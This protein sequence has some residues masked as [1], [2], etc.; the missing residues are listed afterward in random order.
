MMW[1]LG[2]TNGARW[3]SF[4]KMIVMWGL[5]AVITW[6]YLTRTVDDDAVN[7]SVNRV[8]TKK[9]IQFML[10]IM[11]LMPLILGAGTNFSQLIYAF[12]IDKDLSSDKVMLEGVWPVIAVITA[13]L[14][15][16]WAYAWQ[17]V[18]KSLQRSKLKLRLRI[19]H[20]LNFNR[21][22]NLGETCLIVGSMALISLG[23]MLLQVISSKTIKW[24][25]WVE[26]ILFFVALIWMILRAVRL[27]REFR[28][29]WIKATIGPKERV[30]N[31][32][33]VPTNAE[34]FAVMDA[35][36]WI[37]VIPVIANLGLLGWLFWWSSAGHQSQLSH[38]RN[39]EELALIAKQQAKKPKD[40]TKG[41]QAN[42]DY[43]HQIKLAT[44]N[45]DEYS[46]GTTVGEVIERV[47]KPKGVDYIPGEDNPD[48]RVVYWPESYGDTAINSVCLYVIMKGKLND[49]QIYKIEYKID[50]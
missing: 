4:I 21:V 45:G 41:W 43:R 5:A 1:F 20:Y 15:G 23:Y 42:P 46:G 28:L 30:E 40:Y 31:Y 44:K 12:D 29:K 32:Y 17:L 27:L 14:Y 47:G 2:F 37:W 13:S 49:A 50:D 22:L 33:H 18:V 9:M 25:L 16:T 39:E 38:Q 3:E 34:S 36:R 11:I 8:G 7:G 19:D 35:N 6:W 10:V 24:I 26:M 48:V